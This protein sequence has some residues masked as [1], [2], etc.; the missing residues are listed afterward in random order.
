MRPQDVT[1]LFALSA[2]WGASFIFIR[3]VAPSFGAILSAHL[4]VILAGTALLFYCHFKKIDLEWQ[5]HWRRYLFIGTL[6]TAVPFSLYA[7]AG[8]HIPASYSVILNSTSP[9]FSMIVSVLVLGEKP[10]LRKVLGLVTGMLGVSLVIQGGGMTQSSFSGQGIVACLGAALCYGLAGVYL[11]QRAQ[12]LKPQAL[13]A[14]CQI[15]A[16]LVLSPSLF[17]FPGW[18]VLTLKVGLSLMTL[19]FLCSGVAYLLYYRLVSDVGPTKA[20]TVTFL[21]PGFGMLW[22]FLFLQ[23]AITSSMLLGCLFILSGTFLVAS[24]S[25]R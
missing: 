11:K 22:S 4:R 10:T 16:G 6:N 7:F 15:M 3:I 21:M 20:L 18:E 17:F 8:K 12:D 19:A 5:R 25:R 2:I 13:A 9:L 24:P 14:A 23:E 1:R